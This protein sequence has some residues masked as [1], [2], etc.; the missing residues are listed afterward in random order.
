MHKLLWWLHRLPRNAESISVE[1]PIKEG[2]IRVYGWTDENGTPFIGVCALNRIGKATGLSVWQRR[3]HM[4]SDMVVGFVGT[5]PL[6]MNVQITAMCDGLELVIRMP[7]NIK[8]ARD[9]IE[10]RFTPW[11]SDAPS[12]SIMLSPNFEP[13]ASKGFPGW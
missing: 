7:R 10:R 6:V 2:G 1:W 3:S 9:F 5:R 11:G 13:Y 4:T 12:F 8:S